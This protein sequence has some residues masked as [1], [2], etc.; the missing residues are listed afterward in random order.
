MISD[1]DNVNIPT[2][3]KLYQVLIILLS[4]IIILEITYNLIKY[5]N[6]Q[7]YQNLGIILSITYFVKR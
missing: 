2:L 6:N 3:N 4:S 5:D 1:K 7:Y